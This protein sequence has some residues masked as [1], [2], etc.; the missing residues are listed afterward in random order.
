[1]RLF[2][3]QETELMDLFR[4]AADKGASVLLSIQPDS[5]SDDMT[6]HEPYDPNTADRGGPEHWHT[7]SDGFTI[8]STDEDEVQRRH[9]HAWEACYNGYCSLDNTKEFDMREEAEAYREEAV[10][11]EHAWAIELFIG[12]RGAGTSTAGCVTCD[13]VQ[14]IGLA[15]SNH[16]MLGHYSPGHRPILILHVGPVLDTNAGG[17][18]L[19][20]SACPFFYRLYM[21]DVSDD[22]SGFQFGDR[23]GLLPVIISV[24]VHPLL[25][26]PN[27]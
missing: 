15:E 2:K 3:K 24:A 18:T 23:D 11:H 21:H 10:E 25:D 1:M 20:C 19:G 27:A 17:I 13:E 12:K 8:T 7:Y 6:G 5:L 4:M 16:P 22:P 14:S 9:G 26:G